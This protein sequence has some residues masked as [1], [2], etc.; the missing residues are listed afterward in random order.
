MPGF[1]L[2]DPWAHRATVIL[3]SNTMLFRLSL[4]PLAV[5]KTELVLVLHYTK[6]TACGISGSVMTSN[7]PF[8][9]CHSW[10]CLFS[11]QQQWRHRMRP[12]KMVRSWLAL[13]LH[14]VPRIVWVLQPCDTKRLNEELLGSELWLHCALSLLSCL[15]S[16]LSYR[17]L[18]AVTCRVLKDSFPTFLTSLR[19]FSPGTGTFGLVLLHHGGF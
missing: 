4:P 12:V 15:S 9:Y 19:T 1:P 5:G 8:F 3:F 16:K 18:S 6:Q 11:S 10:N 17:F 13:S 2:L 7:W 14:V